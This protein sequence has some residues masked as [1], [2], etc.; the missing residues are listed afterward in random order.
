MLVQ[1]SG[2]VVDADIEGAEGFRSVVVPTITTLEYEPTL[3]VKEGWLFI[4]SSPGVIT[5]ALAPGRRS[6]TLSFR[7]VIRA[8]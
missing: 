7:V 8:P 1:E 5:T 4:G 2:S 6:P 3:G